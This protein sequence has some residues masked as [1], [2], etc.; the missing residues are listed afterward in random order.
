MSSMISTAKN[1][2]RRNFEAGAA[3][4]LTVIIIGVMI[5][6]L[7]MAAAFQG[8]TEALLAGQTDYENYVRSLA[9]TCVDESLYR[10]KLNAAY[11]GGTVPIGV[12][13]CSVSVAGVGSSRTITATAF[14]DIYTKV[15]T[16]AASLKQNVAANAR[17]WHVDSWTESDPP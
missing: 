10:L 6:T 12:D 3:A 13:S 2:V 15:I 7:G 9:Q 17:A 4:L 8:Q 11:A 14:S 1:G 5:L 16:V